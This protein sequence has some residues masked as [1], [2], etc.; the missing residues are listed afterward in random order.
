[1]DHFRI[2][3]RAFNIVRSYRVLWIFGF[4]LALTSSNGG[5]GSNSGYRFGNNNA[6]GNSGQ[7]FPWPPGFQWPNIPQDV[8]NTIIGVTIGVFCLVLLLALAFTLVR[9]VSETSAIRMVDRYEVSGEK[10]RFREGWR[11]G[12]SRAALRMWLVDLIF[13]LGAALV[14]LVLLA[15]AAA[16]LLVWTTQS[17]VARVIGSVAAAGLG[18]L[19]LLLAILVGAVLSLLGKFFHRAIALENLGVF[20]AIRRGWAIVRG[21]PADVIIMG[22]ILFGVGLVF[23]IAMIPIVLVLVAVAAVAGGLPALLAG[24]LTNIFA[25]GFTPQI[26]AVLIGLPIFLAVLALPLTFISGLLE[27]FSSSTWTLTYREVVALETIQPQMPAL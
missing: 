10:V 5:S 18:V 8:M 20:D 13:G 14:F 27:A 15:V 17:D 2:L 24:A 11:L 7:N 12:W 26:V 25:H 22:L 16:P 21:R 9:Y 1:M 19:W 6:G 4:L 23:A 3:R